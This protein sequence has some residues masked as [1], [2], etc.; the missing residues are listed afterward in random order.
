M[1]RVTGITVAILAG[2]WGFTPVLP[3]HAHDSDK[4]T[5]AFSEETPILPTWLQYSS[6]GSQDLTGFPIDAGKAD[7]E[8]TRLADRLRPAVTAAKEGPDV[9]AAFRRVLM[10]EEGF[11]YDRVAGNTENFLAGGVLARKQGNCLGMSLLWLSLAERLGVPFRGVYVPGHCFVRY[12]GNGARV[13]VEFSDGGAP[14]SDGRYLKEFRLTRKEPYL[15]SLSSAEML[16]VFLKSVG[17]AYAKKGKHAEALTIYAEGERNYSGLPDAHYNAAISL[18]R[19]GRADEA[20]AK[21]RKALSL[22]PNLSQARENLGVLLAQQG[23]HSEATD[24]ARRAVEMEPG[25]AVAR[26][27]LASTYCACGDYDG[28]IRE[29]RKV[30]EIDS[31]S[32]QARVG[33][34]RALFAKGDYR[35]AARECERAEALGWRFEPS[36][37]EVLGLYRERGPPPDAHP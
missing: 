16:G 7:R 34:T 28:G 20:I 14:W 3:A 30:L 17:A 11:T 18:Q 21:Y 5:I 15:C 6:S 2:I 27:A 23:R 1:K 25:S 36:V 32:A 12:E 29:Y 33:L 24:E 22:D 8:L 31:S 37:L 26:A 13:N 9:V 4:A 10:K 35:E 19:L